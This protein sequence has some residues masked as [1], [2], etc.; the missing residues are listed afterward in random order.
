VKSE[1]R[2]PHDEVL[3]PADNVSQHFRFRLSAFRFHPILPNFAL[4]AAS[5]LLQNHFELARWN[6]SGDGCEVCAGVHQG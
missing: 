2:N 5:F 6:W 4:L 3:A 1:V